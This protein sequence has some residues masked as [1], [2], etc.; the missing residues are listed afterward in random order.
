MGKFDGRYDAGMKIM[1]GKTRKKRK[2][3]EVIE[4]KEELLVIDSYDGTEHSKITK[5][6]Q[7]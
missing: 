1:L 4:D 7:A 5:A 6:K 2:I 3:D